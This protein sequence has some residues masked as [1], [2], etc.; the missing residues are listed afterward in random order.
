VLAANV[1]DRCSRARF[2]F[3]PEGIA[4]Y[5]Q[6][7]AQTARFRT[8]RKERAVTVRPADDF[9][10]IRVRLKAP[11]RERD[12]ERIATGRNPDDQEVK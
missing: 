7:I 8:E 2:N 5:P 1:I 11:K 3:C 9:A 6:G 10:A 4:V 12:R